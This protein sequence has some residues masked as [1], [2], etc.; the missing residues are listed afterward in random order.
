LLTLRTLGVEVLE[1]RRLLSAALGLGS[2]STVGNSQ[3]LGEL[4]V[5]AEAAISSAIR[6]DLASVQSS[7]AAAA[8]EQAK[9]T[10]SDGLVD[11]YLGDSIAISGNTVVVGAPEATVG[12]NR[13]QGAAYVFVEPVTGWATMTEV[14]K[15]TASDGAA[16]DRF[17][18]SVAIDGQTIV[19]GAPDAHYNAAS[20]SYGPG[21]AYVFVEPA[22]GWATTTQTAELT[23]SDGKSLDGLGTSVAVSGQTVVVGAPGATIGTNSAQGAAYVFV[24]PGSG[25]ANAAQNAKLMASGGNANDGFGSSVAA[26]GNT[27]VVGAPGAPHGAYGP[28]PGA[29]YVFA[30]PVWSGPMYQTAELTASGGLYHD[31]F[32]SSV[33]VSGNTVVVGAPRAPYDGQ[34][35]TDGP[36]SAYV[37]NEPA[38]GWTTATQSATLTA[39]NGAAGNEFGASVSIDGTML[40]AGAPGATV[41]TNAGQG[42]AYVFDELGAGWVSATE[43]AIATASDGAAGDQFG[44]A[45]AVS[46]ST[47]AVGAPDATYNATTHVPGPGPGAGYVFYPPLRLSPGYGLVPSQV[48]AAYGV[49][50]IEVG[51]V[52]GNGAGQTIAIVDAFDDPNLLSSTNSKFDTSDL[53]QFDLEFGLP[54]PPSFLKLD[55][56]GGT[57]YP[58]AATV[59][60]GW[61]GEECL[62]V[63]WAH[64]I[65]PQANIV[66]IETAD[67]S[68]GNLDAG[69]GTAAELP[70][71]SVVSMSWGNGEDSSETFQDALFT[72]P[73][74]HAGVTFLA[75][76]GDNGTPAQGYPAFSPYVVAVGG[77]TLSLSPNNSYGDTYSSESAWSDGG[78][79]VS[80]Y[81]AE[82]NYQKLV[83]TTGMRTIPDVAFDADPNTGVP[84]Y[85]SYDNGSSQPWNEIGGTSL[86]TP[87]WA[88]LIAIADQLRVAQGGTT[89]DGPTQTLPYLYQL[90]QTNPSSFHDIT[91]GNNGTYFAGPGYDLVTG[92]GTPVANLLVPQLAAMDLPTVTGVS[93]SI[94]VAAGGTTVTI[95]GTNLGTVGTAVVKFGTVTA[96]IASDTGTQ[97]V[98]TSPPGTPGTVDV[99]VTTPLGTSATSPADQFTYDPPA[100]A[101]VSGAPGPLAGGTIV[102]ITGTGLA[103]ATAVMFGTQ[104]ATITSDTA[105]RIVVVSP[106]G[107]AGTV[108]VTVVT[109]TGTSAPSSAARFTYVAAPTI[110]KVS[111]ATGPLSGGTV[112][113]ITGTNLSGATAVMFGTV[114]VKKFRVD[115]AGKIVVVSP[116]GT[117]GTVNITVVTAGGTS[118]LTVADQFS[119]VVKKTP[120]A[121]LATADETAPGK[122]IGASARIALSAG[123]GSPPLSGAAHL[124]VSS[125][126]AR[127]AEAAAF[128]TDIDPVLVADVAAANKAKR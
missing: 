126:P 16:S 106:A 92:L 53:H 44:A 120:A 88:G 15:L 71:V 98:A 29:A 69:V 122:S 21:A 49:N 121:R 46:G 128:V 55:Q 91:S 108:A 19:V 94:G 24:E 3:T 61:A 96:T 95:T 54:D 67:D 34:T 32:G 101:K 51:S 80:Q 2:P 60:S 57:N 1:D 110:G 107:Q 86:A 56:N 23:A 22:S 89:L 87:C 104:L 59:A 74:G 26:S 37:Y 82:P 93:P 114:A 20:N 52:V 47:V 48:R 102:T 58:T 65:A 99:T 115:T 4:P 33:A 25:W 105:T 10:A 42:A 64:A 109:A 12:L 43:S 125:S 78:G 97:I 100:V 7:A 83:Q 127:T 11:N 36:G 103:G 62:D 75:A 85:D 72:T 41:G 40:V 90:D 70:G 113:T 39:S 73:P 84:E 66:L 45:V 68:A 31:G 77:T 17:G 5:A 124:D 63:E 50:Q 76:T 18:S 123:A 8:T 111:P 9:L 35:L 14:A 112:V 6:Q 79:G 116:A 117:A 13:Y 119:Y 28:G 30:G 118:A 27:V 81:E 38:A